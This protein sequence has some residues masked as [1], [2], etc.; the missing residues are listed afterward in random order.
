MAIRYGNVGQGALTAALA[1]SSGEAIAAQKAA[2]LA[3]RLAESAEQRKAQQEQFQLTLQAEREKKMIDYTME[4]EKYK[5]AK[6]W[7]IEKMETTSR[8]DFEKEEKSRIQ[9][10]QMYET[11]KQA[12]L[13]ASGLTPEQKKQLSTKLDME[14]I[15]ATSTAQEFGKEEKTPVGIQT[16]MERY[17]L[18]TQEEQEDQETAFNAIDKMNISP[19][20]KEEMKNKYMAKKSGVPIPTSEFG[21][22]EKIPVGIQTMMERYKLKTQEEQ[23]DQVKAFDA[24]DK[25]NISPLEKEELKNKYVARKSGVPIPTSEFGTE[26]EAQKPTTIQSIISTQK[27]LKKYDPSFKKGG[28]TG[29]AIIDE[30]G[31]FVRWGTEPDQRFYNL[32]NSTMQQM[33]TGGT[34]TATT[35]SKQSVAPEVGTKRLINGISYVV[36]NGPQG[37][38]WYKE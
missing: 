11:K 5:R 2:E 10:E 16:I 7:E 12:I 8:L 24:I 29:L 23:E 25:M 36:K 26:P 14:Y 21:K 19:L 28:K 33:I 34:N 13:D 9:K 20:D 3:Q 17:R 18:K 15:G 30:D 1:K 22:E 27:E 37:L 32:L 38:G 31:D 35:T 4:M 6:G